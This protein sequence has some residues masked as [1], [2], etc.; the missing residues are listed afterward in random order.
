MKQLKEYS[1]IL[2]APAGIAASSIEP[3][4]QVST[5]SS[6][7]SPLRPSIGDSGGNENCTLPICVPQPP[8]PDHRLVHTQERTLHKVHAASEREN[9]CAKSGGK[10]VPRLQSRHRWNRAEKTAFAD[11]MCGRTHMSWPE[12]A[13]DYWKITGNQYSVNSLRQL[14]RRMGIQVKCGL[15][16]T[17][18]RSSRSSPLVL[19][20]SL[21]PHLMK[22]SKNDQTANSIGIAIQ[23]Q[24]CEASDRLE[25]PEKHGYDSEAKC[26]AP[27]SPY[28]P[29]DI[30]NPNNMHNRSQG[31][32]PGQDPAGQLNWILN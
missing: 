22:S 12:I 3:A 7:F 9:S 27:N 24:D 16:K 28:S 20:V 25:E 2:S 5:M 26:S 13:D 17:P 32:G 31:P 11:F 15:P 29:R 8:P 18:S 30:P 10:D 14:A 19:K 23:D 1:N 4:N 6:R 21:P